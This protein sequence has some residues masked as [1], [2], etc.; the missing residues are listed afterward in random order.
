MK[1]TK[2]INSLIEDKGLKKVHIAKELGI[3]PHTLSRKLKK[4]ETFN[5]N[6]MAQLSKI[7]CTPV[8]DIDFGVVFFTPKLELKS[9]LK[10]PA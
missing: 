4:P 2:K 9:S 8:E 10:K 7:L 5:A 3:Q 1:E 6:E